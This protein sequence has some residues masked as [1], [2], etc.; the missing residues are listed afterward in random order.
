MA[1]PR[2]GW[3][4]VRGPRRCRPTTGSP[5][6]SAPRRS[7]DRP[8][9]SLSPSCEGYDRAAVRFPQAVEI[10]RRLHRT[11]EPATATSTNAE[12]IVTGHDDEA[13]GVSP[14]DA[15]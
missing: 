4:A 6:R 7:A 3:T 1:T 14:D 2:S 9:S 8:G 10:L 5:W 13:T 11:I 15:A 12:P